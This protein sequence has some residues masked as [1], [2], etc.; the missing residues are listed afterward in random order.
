MS[1][2][3]NPPTAEE[4][5]SVRQHFNESA[6]ADTELTVLA[7][8]AGLTWYFKGKGETARKYLAYDFEDLNSVPGMVGKKSRIRRLIDILQ[9]TVAFDEPFAEMADGIKTDIDADADPNRI[10]L[11]LGIDP[12][13][14]SGLLHF[15]AASVALLK[16]QSLETLGHLLA[17]VDR[18]AA[19][20]ELP[21]DC[22][23]LLNC[24]VH[25]DGI[26]TA[27]YLPFRVGGKGLHLA[28]SIGLIARDIPETMQYALL[29]RAGIDLKNAEYAA[30]SDLDA[31]DFEKHLTQASA[32]IAIACNWFKQEA[33]ELSAKVGSATDTERFFVP[34]NHPHRERVAA[35]LARI[36]FGVDPASGKRS[37]FS[38]ILKAVGRS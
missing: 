34:L 5:N 21:G 32:R 13:L 31:E 25:R 16:E 33:E 20:I 11:R 1:K 6:F 38:S 22:K 9:S 28:E 12:D 27:R 30:T 29:K 24:L 36:H 15:N 10:L 2:S 35:V 4:W 17:Y 18:N 8:N 3:S 14:P 26:G 23:A 7:Q 37:L 19:Q